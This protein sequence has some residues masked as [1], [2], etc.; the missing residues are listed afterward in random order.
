V[1]T[2]I[3]SLKSVLMKMNNVTVDPFALP[4]IIHTM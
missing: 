2:P 1:T 4:L 3:T